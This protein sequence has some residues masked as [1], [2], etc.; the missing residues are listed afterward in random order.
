M[1]RIRK[2]Q[3]GSDS[4]GNV[5]KKDGDV[6]DV[7]HEQAEAL[8]L[9]EDGQFWLADGDE[10]DEDNTPQDDPDSGNAAG[11]GKTRT[12]DDAEPTPVNPVFSEVHPA[13]PTGEPAA[14]DAP[15]ASPVQ[16]GDD[17]RVTTDDKP[18]PKP[19][20]AAKKTAARKTT[21]TKPTE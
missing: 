12:G 9:I 1:P 20:P 8:L 19:E 10:T 16:D 5:W 18:E 11:S 3:A 14:V 2:V 7:P 13:A 6:V 21:A 4:F 15:P 17:P